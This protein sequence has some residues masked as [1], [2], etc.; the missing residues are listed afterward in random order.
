MAT[1]R[2]VNAYTSLNGMYTKHTSGWR[3]IAMAL[4]PL[5]IMFGAL[6]INLVEEFGILYVK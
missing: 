3:A 5:C 1:K 4:I 2:N 6:S